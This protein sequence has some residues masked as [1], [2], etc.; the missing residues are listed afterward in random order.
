MLLIRIGLPLF[1]GVPVLETSSRLVIVLALIVKTPVY[2]L[3]LWL[4]KAHVEAPTIGSVILA[5]VL[6]K[7]RV[8]GLYRLI[9]ALRSTALFVLILITMTGRGVRAIITLTQVDLKVL[10]AYSSVVHMGLG[11][12]R[13]LTKRT[14]AVTRRLILIVAHGLARIGLFFT[15]AL[16]YERGATRSLVIIN[17]SL[18]EAAPLLLM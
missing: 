8:V 5:A 1:S 16:L 10:I 9:P 11:V 15:G 12:R 18:I 17:G 13:L 2:G 3:H 4:P 6:L 7:L 14:G